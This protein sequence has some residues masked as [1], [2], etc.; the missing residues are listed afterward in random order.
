MPIFIG[1][2]WPYA[3]G[4]LHLGH[5]SS[6]LPGD[7]L[8]RYYRMK[9]EDV[10]YVS[11]SDCHG[12][13][14][15]IRAE[16]EG[17][18]PSAI[19]DFYHQEFTECFRQLG[20]SYDLYTRTDA[21]HHYHYVQE[22]F[23][24]L[25]NSG[26]LELREVGQ[27]YCPAC[28]KF[29]PD[30]YVEG[31]CPR[32]GAHARGD[33]CEACQSVLDPTD[34]TERRCKLCGAEP[35]TRSTQHYYLLLS[36]FQ[37]ELER[38]A[39]EAEGWRENA[40]H[41]TRRYLEE[42]LVD[43]AATRDLPW[44][45]D[46]PVEGFEGKKIYVWIEAVSGYWT[47]SRK[48]A[49]DTGNDYL[50]FWSEGALAYYIHGKDNIPFHTVILPALLLGSGGLHLPDRIVS[51]E[52]L[53]L[54]GQKISTSRGWAVWVPDVLERYE[55][56]SLRYFI[57]VNSPEK[58]DGDFSWHEFIRSH[59]G[60]LVNAFGN[61]V[62][63]SLVFIVKSFDGR[64][65]NG[66]LDES[67]ERELRGLYDRM[68]ALIEKA[69]LKKA[70]EEC[71]GFIRRAN[72][73]FDERKPWSEVQTNPPHA[74]DTLYTCVQIIAN[75]ERLLSPF[76]PFACAK[77]AGF[78]GEP[79]PLSELSEP[80]TETFQAD[81]L[82]SHRWAFT[83]VASGT[84]LGSIEPLFARIDPAREAEETERLAAKLKA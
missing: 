48:W 27:T 63:R 13:P 82:Q 21:P 61:F 1:G 3:N 66:R 35:E 57:T 32:C 42:G 38:Y 11:G 71:F 64:V 23:L 52:Y 15:A 72:K 17:V 67:I 46:V 55:P 24:R 60:E 40:V 10:L 4:S 79:R 19:A 39:R 20:F 62:H 51:G 76:L 77:L 5:L 12:T 22:L 44:G 7:I 26:C 54:E 28:S 45:I 30:R 78:L 31:T 47:A 6:L 43:R 34:L 56:D 65:P 68:S 58:H 59:N 2:A 16:K 53:T 14:I 70:L 73:Y 25:L 37:E 29:L 50:P 81:A 75:L 18:E 49:E 33:Q 41:L 80:D 9:G 74:A 8:A 84:V 69:E 36:R 83:E